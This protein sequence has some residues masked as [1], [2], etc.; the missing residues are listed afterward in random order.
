MLLFNFVVVV[1]FVVCWLLLFVNFCCRCYGCCV[2]CWSF[3]NCFVVAV[4]VVVIVVVVVVGGGGGCV[5]VCW[6]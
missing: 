2:G 6:L 3:C 5:V 1:V 4:L